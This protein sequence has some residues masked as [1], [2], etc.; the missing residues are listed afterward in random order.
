MGGSSTRGTPAALALQEEAQAQGPPPPS[1]IQALQRPSTATTLRVVRESDLEEHAPT[2]QDLMDVR[3]LAVDVEGIG[4]SRTGPATWLVLC[5]MLHGAP[6]VIMV[7]IEATTVDEQV[8]AWV[9]SLLQ[10]PDAGPTLLFWDVRNDAD[11]LAHQLGI[12]RRGP[13]CPGRPTPQRPGHSRPSSPQQPHCPLPPWNGPGAR[14]RLRVLEY[15]SC[16]FSC[17]SWGP[18]KRSRPC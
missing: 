8:A 7:W 11:A 16:R 3:F 9:T 13:S 15:R 10:T 14:V 17:T 4:L 1:L 2:L 18:N 6:V 12:P 5:A